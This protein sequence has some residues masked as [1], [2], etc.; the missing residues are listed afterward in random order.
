MFMIEFVWFVSAVVG[1]EKA[2]GQEV[3]EN[4]VIE[5]SFHQN[6]HLH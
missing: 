4:S 3:S 6:N 2:G 1:D 5:D